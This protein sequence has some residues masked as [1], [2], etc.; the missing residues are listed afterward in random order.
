M[1][2]F[3]RL[4]ANVM[5][6]DLPTAAKIVWAAL[7]MF[8]N[9]KT[10]QCNP[11]Q[12]QIAAAVGSSERSIRRAL[13]ALIA[14]GLVTVDT[15]QNRRSYSLNP[16]PKTPVDTGHKRRSDRTK[17]PVQPVKTAA[18][19][20]KEVKDKEKTSKKQRGMGE[21]SIFHRSARELWPKITEQTYS[22]GE[23][24]NLWKKHGSL[25]STALESLAKEKR[26]VRKPIPY[27]KTI[28]EKKEE[29][30][31]TVVKL[32]D[33]EKLDPWE[34]Q[35]H[36]SKITTILASQPEDYEPFGGPDE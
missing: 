4:D 33:V 1:N 2:R 5:S 19:Y 28:L 8:Q 31:D 10:N 16:E 35:A 3:G 11:S 34:R 36:D 13:D 15:G 32:V 30:K 21:L 7:R 25:L 26:K 22:A 29:P 18:R 23:L 17:T 20:N 6:S 14:K 24:T 27:L 9:P 12:E